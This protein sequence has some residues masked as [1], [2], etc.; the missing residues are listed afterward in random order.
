MKRQKLFNWMWLSF[1]GSV[2]VVFPA[3]AEVVQESQGSAVLPNT[4]NSQSSL[5]QIPRLN[6][7]DRPA[8][9]IEEW[10]SQ[11]PTL[12]PDSPVQII[13]V[14][15][16]STTD[17]IDIILETAGGEA[18]DGSTF[19]EGNSLIVDIPNAQLQLPE[20]EE[21]RQENPVEGI[22]SINV[23]N[24]TSDSVRVTVTGTT[25]I[26]AGAVVASDRGLT[27]SLSPLVLDEEFEIIVTAE[28][29]PENVQDVPVSITAIP[30]QEIEDADIT[31]IRDISTNTPNFASFTPGRSFILYSV[32]GLS[33][34]NFLSRDPVAFYVDDVP[35]D[36]SGFLTIEQPDLERVEVLRGPQSTLYGRNAQGGVVNIITRKPTNTFEFNG[37]ASYGN[38]DALDFR[39]GISGPL[40]EDQLFF[41]LSGS[42]GSRDGY[43]EN[44]FLDRDVDDQSGG[45]GRAQLL[46]TPSPDWD[47][48]FNASFD[49]YR[50]GVL[51]NLLGQD[52]SE[53]MQDFQNLNDLVSNTQSLRVVYKQPDFR[54][55]S[56]TA[57]RFSD[58]KSATDIDIT[59]RDIFTSEDALDSTV[60]SQEIR[61]QSPEGASR[62][63]WL[64]GGY[65]ESR[66][67]NVGANDF[68][69]GSDGAALGFTPGVNQLTAETS[70]ITKAVFAQASYQPIDAVTL[71]AGLRY[72]SSESN[73]DNRERT[74]VPADGSA[75]FTSGAFDDIEKDG[76]IVLPRF[77]GEYRFNPNV[78]V[79]GSIARGYKPPGVN[80]RAETQET[81]T[82]E[83]EKS[84]NYEIGLKSS[85]LDDRL[86]VNLAVFHNPVNDYQV[87]VPDATGFFRDVANAEVEITGFE[88][89]AR[90]TPVNGFDIIAGFGFVDA[91]FTDYTNPFSG[92]VFNGNKLPY[93]PDFTYNLALQ[94]RDRSG[95]FGRVELQGSGTMFFDDANNF[96]QS[97]FARLN[98]RLG[99]EFDNYGVYFFANNIT[100]VRNL[101]SL[102]DFPGIGT[103]ITYDSPVTYGVQF[104]FQF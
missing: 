85:W 60:F 30:R 93:A 15:L 46:W 71:T 81:L 28:K 83:A 41:R 49:D 17:G 24:V 18:L 16:N 34:F 8:T 33:N 61:L 90:A 98:A 99:Y 91:E 23:T 101:T 27:L 43:I 11:S 92:E 9:T 80:F 47:I 77:I 87:P 69:T 70:D 44:T 10:L 89:E 104:K 3:K 36:Y 20:D 14:Q 52:L 66:D 63:E 97:S 40:I 79:Y 75:S 67:F 76:D 26:P 39:A 103:F 84:W 1:A 96:Q 95:L 31:S 12:I 35:Y 13:G 59:I 7:I 19:T 82:Y 86:A 29:R 4:S 32:R 37:S 56:I 45:T 55:T 102:G 94:Y 73:L 51:L 88:V 64:L 25:E 2:F 22:T 65:F 50:D 72:E 100:D 57:R 38:Y 5:T 54:V 74:F 42:Y 68:R 78:M 62:F 21:F 53:V 58:Q 48:S 6:E